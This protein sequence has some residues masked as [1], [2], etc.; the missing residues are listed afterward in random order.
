MDYPTHSTVAAKAGRVSPSAPGRQA[1]SYKPVRLLIP[2]LAFHGA[3]GE[4][5]PT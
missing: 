1:T 5:R 2:P 3:L 4:T